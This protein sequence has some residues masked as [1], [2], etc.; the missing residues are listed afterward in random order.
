M[1]DQDRDKKENESAGQTRKSQKGKKKT[2]L[3]VWRSYSRVKQFEMVFAA[4]AAA[5]VVGYLIAYLVVSGQQNSQAQKQHMPLLINS[6][7]P[8]LLQPFVCD[9]KRGL[10]TGNIETGVQNLGTA[11]AYH[12]MPFINMQKL[13]PEHKRGD[14]FF[15]ALPEANCKLR[16]K[17][18]ELESP[19]APGQQMRPQ[20][21][22]MVATIPPITS[23]EP[24][25]LYWVSCIYYGDEYGGYH[26]TCDTY[27]LMLPS[28]NP[29]DL[30]HG[31]PSFFCDAIP[32]TGKFEPTVTGHCHED[33]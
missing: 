1:K 22:Q 11:S 19:L 27:R 25:Q 31:S 20:I 13:V 9:V 7:A 12:V 26:S 32:K 14:P 21:R 30:I 15:D 18:Q 10:H 5:G 2:F 17:A 33:Y 8:T 16:P 3:Q 29:L 28:D 6:V 4:L 24:V 23:D